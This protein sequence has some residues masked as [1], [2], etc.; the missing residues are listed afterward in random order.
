MAGLLPQEWFNPLY[1]A[2]LA[3][4]VGYPISTITVSCIAFNNLH[5]DILIKEILD[6]IW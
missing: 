2:G 4:S 1:A 6:R 3:S 5:D